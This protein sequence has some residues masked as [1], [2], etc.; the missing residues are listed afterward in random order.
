MS[1]KEARYSAFWL[2][3]QALHT[4]LVLASNVHLHNIKKYTDRDITVPNIDIT[5]DFFL[6]QVLES[7]VLPID[8]IHLAP[9]FKCVAVKEKYVCFGIVT[10]GR[11]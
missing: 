8:I 2:T 4:Q 9:V 5:P 10:G 11:R 7:A 1:L 6:P 3:H